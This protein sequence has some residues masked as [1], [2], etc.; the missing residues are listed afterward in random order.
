M[1]PACP[2]QEVKPYPCTNCSK[3]CPPGWNFCERCCLEIQSQ[4]LQIGYHTIT[5]VTGLLPPL[6]APPPSR[7]VQ[8]TNILPGQQDA[9]LQHLYPPADR[10]AM[11]D[12]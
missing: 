10:N 3:D 7:L 12:D 5:L 11:N 1:N 2:V 6:P 4:G 9:F 8:A